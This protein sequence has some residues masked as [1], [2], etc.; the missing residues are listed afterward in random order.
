MCASSQIYNSQTYR[1]EIPYLFDLFK[2]TELITPDN[3]MSTVPT[4]CL[5]SQTEIDKLPKEVFTMPMFDQGDE[6]SDRKAEHYVGFWFKANNKD[7]EVGKII[8]QIGKKCLLDTESNMV[9]AFIYPNTFRYMPHVG[10]IKLDISE[11]DWDRWKFFSYTV[12]PYKRVM[13]IA[14]Y[15]G[16]KFIQSTHVFPPDIVDPVSKAIKERTINKFKLDVYQK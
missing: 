7:S 9:E 4:D 14:Y 12:D 2:A 6:D 3:R 13:D 1:C 8:F 10:D 16:H 11:D 15:N 5:T